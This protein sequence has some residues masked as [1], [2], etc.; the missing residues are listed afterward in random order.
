MLIYFIASGKKS[1]TAHFEPRSP[2]NDNFMKRVFFHCTS[3]PRQFSLFCDF[4]IFQLRKQCFSVWL[5]PNKALWH[6]IAAEIDFSR[7]S[8]VVECSIKSTKQIDL[9]VFWVPLFCNDQKTYFSVYSF[10]LYEHMLNSF[11][12]WAIKWEFK[13]PLDE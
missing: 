7:L 4:K 5:K 1:S 12:R 3:R 8:Q 9:F 2:G 13:K 10:W 11:K 6:R